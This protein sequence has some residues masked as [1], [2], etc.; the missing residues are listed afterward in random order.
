[1]ALIKCPECGRENVSDNAEACPNCGFGIREYYQKIKSEQQKEEKQRREVEQ[2]KERELAQKAQEEQRIKNIPKP[3]KPRYSIA[4]AICGALCILLGG[5]SVATTNEYEIER[6]VSAGNGDPVFQGWYLIISGVVILCVGLYFF[7]KKVNAYKLAKDDF[8]AY[9]KEV[10]KRQ[11]EETL[12]HVNEIQQKMN[13][14]VKCPTCGSTNV[15]KINGASKVGKAAVFG[16]L[17]AG[18]IS[19]TFHCKNCG[20]RW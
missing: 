11:D 12:R 5:N 1:M 16:V 4:A 9:Q 6:S 10:V 14:M 20:Y 8:E 17:A 18:S 19:K 3:D 2:R 15:E 13:A 7:M